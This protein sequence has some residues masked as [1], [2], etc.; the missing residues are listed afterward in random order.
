MKCLAEAKRQSFSFDDT[1]MSWNAVNLKAHLHGFPGAAKISLALVA[2]WLRRH[3]VKVQQPHSIATCIILHRLL[4]ANKIRHFLFTE[5]TSTK[6]QMH[7]TSILEHMKV[8]LW[9]TASCLWKW[10]S[11]NILP[12]LLLFKNHSPRPLKRCLPSST[13][14]SY[15]QW[16][17]VHHHTQRPSC[18]CPSPLLPVPGQSAIPGHW[19]PKVCLKGWVLTVNSAC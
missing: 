8:L 1:K 18:R 16:G 5:I 17:P 7:G 11:H 10:R 2:E 14:A 6:N 4:S 19:L 3:K 13:W 9:Q 15:I 12:F